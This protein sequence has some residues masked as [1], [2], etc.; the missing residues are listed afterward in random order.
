MKKTII[1]ILAAFVFL[2]VAQTALAFDL[3]LEDTTITGSGEVSIT[4]TGAKDLGA[5]DLKATYD[6]NLLKLESVELGSVSKNGMVEYK[7]DGGSVSISCVDSDGISKDGQL[8]KMK[9]SALGKGVSDSALTA[10]AY[11]TDLKDMQV[12]AKGGKITAGS[13]SSMMWIIIGAVILA[14]IS[15]FALKKKK[16]EPEAKI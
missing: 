4:V 11:G 12:E 16:R 5:V 6:K 3:K 9:F 1:S 7:D 13:S 15:F 2:A 10:S 8:L 14:A